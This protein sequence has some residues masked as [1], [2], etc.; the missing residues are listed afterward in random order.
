MSEMTFTV[1]SDIPPPK[2]TSKTSDLVVALRSM[3][4][5]QSVLVPGK[6]VRDIKSHLAVAKRR[7]DK[8]FQSRTLTTGVRIW[9]L[10]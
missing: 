2:S 8:F 7:T 1:E 4:I 3:E 6:T 5:G 9:R 10:E